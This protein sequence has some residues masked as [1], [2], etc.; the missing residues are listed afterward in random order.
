[1]THTPLQI[2]IEFGQCENWENQ[3]LK[4]S[5]YVVSDILP[6]KR[7][8]ETNGGKWLNI[9]D[10]GR[11]HWYE[12]FDLEVLSLFSALGSSKLF[13]RNVLQL[14]YDPFAVKTQ[15]CHKWNLNWP[16]SLTG[17][18]QHRICIWKKI[19][20]NVNGLIKIW[21]SKEI[22]VK[23]NKVLKFYAEMKRNKE[24]IK[25]HFHSKRNNNWMLNPRL[26]RWSFFAQHKYWFIEGQY[27]CNT[28][29][30]RCDAVKSRRRK[31]SPPI[32]THFSHL[33]NK[34]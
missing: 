7:N 30:L 4:K 8:C 3:N 14:A 19:Q 31:P 24:I 28:F 13:Q 17:K 10:C 2:W 32:N 1:M 11:R 15:N 33:W 26:F 12:H 34:S 16:K 5:W 21:I 18:K 6:K 22:H 27:T 23:I 20:L 9:A 29:T 25:F